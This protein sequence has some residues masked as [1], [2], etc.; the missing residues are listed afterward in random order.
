MTP[1]EED[2]IKVYVDSKMPSDN[3]LVRGF[4]LS[5]IEEQFAL[6]KTAGYEHSIDQ[7]LLDLEKEDKT[8]KAYLQE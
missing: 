4:F 5:C 2:K 1:E 3:G 6:F 8:R 7:F